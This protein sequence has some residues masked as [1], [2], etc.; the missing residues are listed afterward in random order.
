MMMSCETSW[1]LGGHQTETIFKKKKLK[2]QV[3]QGELL[4]NTTSI[5]KE[6]GLGPESL[7]PPHTLWGMHASG[8]GVI[9]MEYKLYVRMWGFS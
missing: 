1:W 9:R 7:S 5:R 8:T 6:K 4:S 2:F 3:I